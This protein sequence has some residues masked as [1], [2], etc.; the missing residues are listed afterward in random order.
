MC[1]RKINI[2][3]PSEIGLIIYISALI[4]IIEFHTM[5]YQCIALEY[6][7]HVWVSDF[8]IKYYVYIYIYIYIFIYINIYIF[9]YIYIFISIYTYMY[10]FLCGGV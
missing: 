2:N 7:V 6:V 4:L 3:K 10:I 8:I 1:D 9:K 5:D